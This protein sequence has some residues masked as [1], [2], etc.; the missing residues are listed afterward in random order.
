MDGC[1]EPFETDETDVEM[2]GGRFCSI[3]RGGFEGIRSCG[4]W[5]CD[6]KAI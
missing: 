1:W 3:F 2:V 5:D 6:L 4:W